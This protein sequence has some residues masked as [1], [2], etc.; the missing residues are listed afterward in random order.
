M[1]GES[2][3]SPLS[4]RGQV[5]I[6]PSASLPAPAT[7]MATTMATSGAVT[8]LSQFQCD[9]MHI[10]PPC[11]LGMK[12][13]TV[14]TPLS[15]LPN[16]NCIPLSCAE[17]YREFLHPGFDASRYANNVIQGATVATCLDK[18][19]HGVRQLEADLHAQVHLSVVRVDV[20]ATLVP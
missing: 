9:G 16:A 3:R 19:S 2:P 8:C 15:S 11:S 6:R 7:P 1:E 17:M 14:C 5:S 4:G 20:D 13:N 12:A 18:I 10:Q